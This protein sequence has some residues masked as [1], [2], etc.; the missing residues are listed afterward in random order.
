V[1]IYAQDTV[2]VED[3]DKVILNRNKPKPKPDK[4]Y[5]LVS[6][7]FLVGRFGRGQENDEIHQHQ[8]E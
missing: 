5:S 3:E 7:D 4:V 6:F 1:L 8:Y 2:D